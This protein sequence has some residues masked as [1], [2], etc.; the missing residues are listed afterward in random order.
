MCLL[1]GVF[2][3]EGD[4]TGAGVLERLEEEAGVFGRNT[5]GVF[6]RL[7]LALDSD[8]ALDGIGATGRGG[9]FE[10]DCEEYSESTSVV[11]PARDPVLDSCACEYVVYPWVER[12]V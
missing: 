1:T 10:Y 4:S 11:P 8:V 2:D 5:E 6:G 12:D 9:S 7:T 3:R